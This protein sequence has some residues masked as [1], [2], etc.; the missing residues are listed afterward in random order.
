MNSPFSLILKAFGLF[1]RQV[2]YFTKMNGGKVNH[3]Q[4]SGQAKAVIGVGPGES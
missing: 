3:R 2:A 4:Q 1:F